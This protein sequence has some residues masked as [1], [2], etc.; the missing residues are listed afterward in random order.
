VGELGARLGPSIDILINNAELHGSADVAEPGGIDR[1][2][3][4]MEVNYFGLLRLAQVFGPVMR[5]ALAWVNILSIYALASLP[6]ERTFSASKA[7]ACSL[8]QAL[9]A[10]MQPSGMRVLNI[11][12]GPIAPDA[13]AQAVVKGLR[14][15][16][17]DVYP[18]DAA[19][20]WFER[21]RESPKAL[22]RELAAAA[23][24]NAG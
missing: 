3:A 22:E 7:A 21:W 4:E 1:A 9:R 19:Q 24:A 15:G 6:S 20:E 2:H 17:E 13:L 8:A 16:V 11:F 14:D 5:G 10:E 18:G 23:T 12:P